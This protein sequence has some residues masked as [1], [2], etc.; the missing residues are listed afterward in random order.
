MP[1]IDAL[2]QND[3]ETRGE[4]RSDRI[5]ILFMID[6][7]CST[8]GAERMAVGL[9]T[10]LRQDRFEPWMC[11][12]RETDPVASQAL[13]D[14]GIPAEIFLGNVKKQKHFKYVEDKNI[15]YIV[16]SRRLYKTIKLYLLITLIAKIYFLTY[17][18]NLL[19]ISK[20]FFF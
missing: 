10:H 15:A 14:A 12:T 19:Y 18:N 5:R 3:P 7:A 13:R 17:S 9:A 6:Y 11:A 2:L 8:G 20:L 16:T 1:Q 4:A